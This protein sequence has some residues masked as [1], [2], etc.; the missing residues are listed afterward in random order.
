M[1][2]GYLSDFKHIYQNGLNEVF[3]ACLCALALTV[4]INSHLPAVTSCTHGIKTIN[5]LNIKTQIFE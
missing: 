1:Q 4:K 3:H 2:I 5:F